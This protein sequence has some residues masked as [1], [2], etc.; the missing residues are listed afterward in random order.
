MFKL[1][2][3]TKASRYF[4]VLIGIESIPI[5]ELIAFK[6]V[7]SQNVRINSNLHTVVLFMMLKAASRL[8]IND[9]SIVKISPICMFNQNLGEKKPA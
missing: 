7:F 8:N 9:L 3:N 5:A 2:L 6:G 1:G 4:L